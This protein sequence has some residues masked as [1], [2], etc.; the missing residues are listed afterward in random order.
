MKSPWGRKHVI[1]A[2]T[3]LAV[4]GLDQWTK[5]LVHHRFQWGES[6]PIFEKFF[7][8]TYVRNLGAAFGVLNT[9]PVWF[10]DP[11][12]IL[13]PV[14]VMAVIV[15]LILY[16]PKKQMGVAFALSL[17]FAG[18]LGNLIDRLRLGYVIDFLDFYW[19]QN[20]WPSF[21]LADSSIV[22]GASLLFVTTCLAEVAERK[23][24]PATAS[25]LGV[26]RSKKSKSK[27]VGRRRGS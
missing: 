26:R 6:R 5:L 7:S 20:H 16:L 14:V 1:L 2:L 25:S 11:F 17:I 19:G 3:T 27:S 23:D 24:K 4:V 10:R 8:L 13:V 9:A 15:G 22:V 21:N 18:A 12:F